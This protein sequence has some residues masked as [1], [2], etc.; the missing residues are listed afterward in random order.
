MARPHGDD[1]RVMACAKLI[2]ALPDLLDGPNLQA[3]CD[4]L[5]A[6]QVLHDGQED[7]GAVMV[8]GLEIELAIAETFRRFAERLDCRRAD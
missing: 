2:D 6:R 8:E 5:T 1:P 3:V 7:P 4:W